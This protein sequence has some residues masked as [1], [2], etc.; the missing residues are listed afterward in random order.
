MS[1]TTPLQTMIGQLIENYEEAYGEALSGRELSSMLG[2][3]RN[4]LSQIMNDGLIPSGDVLSKLCDVLEATEVER[5]E[6]ML[7]AMRTKAQG[8]ARD[9]FWLKRALEMCDDFQ[10]EIEGL[11]QYLQKQGKLDDYEKWSKRRQRSKASAKKRK[12]SR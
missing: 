1:S 2:K 12:R 6:L 11:R 9:T 7:A 3:S 4:H 8:R 5:R 10:A